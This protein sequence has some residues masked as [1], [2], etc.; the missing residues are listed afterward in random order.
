LILYKYRSCNGFTDSILKDQKIWLARSATLNDPC[1]CSIHDIAPDWVDEK[2]RVMRSAQ[3]A[4]FLS[5]AMLNAPPLFK[6]ISKELSRAATFDQKYAAFRKLYERNTKSSLSDPSLSFRQIDEQLK[7]VGVF[8]L[9]E[10]PE[11]PLMW[12]HYGQ[13]HEGVCLGFEMGDTA[14]AST[15]GWLSKV[16]YSDEIPKMADEFQHE[17]TLAMSAGRSVAQGRIPITDTS[18]RTAITTKAR[19]WE[20]EREWRYFQ[21]TGDAAYPFAGPLVEIVFGF[22]C[23]VENQQ[24]Y[25]DLASRYVSNDLRMFAMTRVRNSFTFEKIPFPAI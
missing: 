16:T 2:V 23:T 12:S 7:S 17:V 25:R 13:Q 22:R 3:I 9:S 1:E 5:N 19:C 8:S 4:G 21:V 6:K 18:I 20:Y 14:L 15:Q 24:R 10:D 11:H